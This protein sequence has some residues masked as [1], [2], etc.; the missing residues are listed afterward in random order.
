[1]PIIILVYM[2]GFCVRRCLVAGRMWGSPQKSFVHVTSA[3][4][5]CNV[6]GGVL[7]AF[8]SGGKDE[9]LMNSLSLDLYF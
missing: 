5:A 4:H 7:H 1:M 8:G 6:S 9:W 2:G 3:M